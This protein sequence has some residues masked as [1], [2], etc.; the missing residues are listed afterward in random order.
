M[1]EALF[2]SPWGALLILLSRIVDVSIDTMRVIFAIRGR[3]GIAA[4]LGGCQAAIW[5]IV[6]S[7]A[8]Q[9]V[10]SVLHVLGYAGG[11]AA[12]TFVG[13]TIERYV[14][15]GTAMLR[16][17]SAH[18]GPGIAQALRERGYGVTE[19]LGQGREGA[20]T[21]LFAAIERSHLEDAMEI[22][23]HH[24]ASAFITVEEPK[25]MQGGL[26]KTREWPVFTPRNP[27]ERT[28]DGG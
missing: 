27:F 9:H 6:V 4:L 11:Y 10:D 3:R 22:A 15:Y 19:V 23:M 12:G 7:Q 24:D 14:A 26:L 21:I 2:A 5:I 17:V 8:V 28:K 25:I 20:V 18:G 16:I 13:V 1:L